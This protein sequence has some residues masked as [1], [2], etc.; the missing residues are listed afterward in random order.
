MLNRGQCVSR[1]ALL[2]SVW[3]LEPTQTT[4]IVDVYVNYLRRKLKDPPPG[5]L[6]HTV[7]GQGYMVPPETG[8]APSALSSL[9][10]PAILPGV[11]IPALAAPALEAN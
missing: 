3:N 7:R 4:N 5:V 10:L 1:V 11:T 9:P 8:I 2:D 6:I